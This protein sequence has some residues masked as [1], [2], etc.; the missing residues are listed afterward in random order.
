MDKQEVIRLLL[1]IRSQIGA[2]ATKS[3]EAKVARQLMGLSIAFLDLAKQLRFGSLEL[4]ADIDVAV[5][6]LDDVQQALKEEHPNGAMVIVEAH[7]AL[8]MFGVYLNPGPALAASFAA[9]GLSWPPM[10]EPRPYPPFPPFPPYP[11]PPRPWWPRPRP[12]PPF[13]PIP[14]IPGPGPWPPWSDYDYSDNY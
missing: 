14:P 12:R 3:N 11:W 10:P 6:E 8:A 7:E 4:P 13:P 2:L 5:R 9:P 1:L